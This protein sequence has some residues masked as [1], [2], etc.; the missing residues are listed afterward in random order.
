[1]YLKPLGSGVRISNTCDVPNVEL[2]E[3]PIVTF[4]FEDIFPVV[5][6]VEDVVVTAV[7]KGCWFWYVI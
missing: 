2:Q 3:V 4:F 7:L 1:M 5:T 6:A